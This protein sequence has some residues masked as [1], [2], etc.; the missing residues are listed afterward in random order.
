M[1]PTDSP[2]GTKSKRRKGK[3]SSADERRFAQLDRN[4]EEMLGG[5]KRGEVM[6]VWVKSS[7]IVVMD[8][9]VSLQMPPEPA[10]MEHAA[11]MVDVQVES[12]L[13]HEQLWGRDN[14]RTIKFA[15]RLIK[16]CN[17]Y[18]TS[19]LGLGDT[20]TALLMFQKASEV[21]GAMPA[22]GDYATKL[23]LRCLTYS[24]LAWFHFCTKDFVTA[25][26]YAQ[27]SHSS[28]NMSKDQRAMAAAHLN[29]GCCISMLGRHEGAMDHATKAL[30]LLQ[31]EHGGMG[32][33]SAVAVCL[34][35]IGV[36]QI[37]LFR[38]G[39]GTGAGEALE[40]VTDAIEIA[41]EVLD[42]SHTWLKH[43]K[44]TFKV[45]LKMSPS[46]DTLR[47]S[48]LGPLKRVRS[49]APQIMPSNATMNRS[50][51]RTAYTPEGGQLPKIRSLTPD[52]SGLAPMKGARTAD[53]DLPPPV[54]AP[55]VRKAPS[56]LQP[57][58]VS[59]PNSLSQPHA[60]NGTPI[61]PDSRP[62]SRASILGLHKTTSPAELGDELQQL[63][64]QRSK[65][66]TDIGTGSIP[67]LMTPTADDA[68]LQATTKSETTVITTTLDG[69]KPTE[70]A[71]E[72]YGED[73]G[74]EAD[75]AYGDDDFAP[76]EKS[77]AAAP[78]EPAQEEY[79]EDE[80]FEED[81]DY[82]DDFDADEE[83]GA[84]LEK[85][86][87]AAAS[88]IQRITR[89][90]QGRKKARD[91]R[92][93]KIGATAAPAT[94]AAA[95]EPT[96]EQMQ[97]ELDTAMVEWKAADSTDASV[98]ARAR[99]NRARAALG[100]SPASSRA[101]SPAKNNR[102]STELVQEQEDTELSDAD[103]EARAQAALKIQSLTRGKA[104][105]KKAKS[106]ATN[107]HTGVQRSDLGD[108]GAYQNE[109]DRQRAALRIQSQARAR[110]ARK[111]A[112]FVKN[113]PDAQTKGYKQFSE[114][115][116]D[117]A[118]PYNVKLKKGKKGPQG[119]MTSHESANVYANQSD[120]SYTHQTAAL[121]IQSIQRGKIGRRNAK[122]K[123]TSRSALGP[124]VF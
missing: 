13:L 28:A 3:K 23:E 122:K 116:G 41:K 21:L 110:R 111:Q 16:T 124:A 75:E 114:Y 39:E 99:V 29:V 18:G 68:L 109:I 26:K 48:G 82:G 14:P 22:Q 4:A 6:P 33:N 54:I 56:K 77:V 93:T 120:Y 94:T 57:L 62:E 36:E 83:A 112:E 19:V 47:K 70:E 46:V 91:K 30:Y 34:H 5:G 65:M 107:K 118:H 40:S 27:K 25:L 88:N 44:R 2:G 8:T 43:F 72:N 86:K 69:Y 31:A 102:L 73:D 105:R 100:K 84:D 67:R 45:A 108:G 97:A 53:K 101:P 49:P 89:G 24:N 63:V 121:R 104:G 32:S 20:R 117:E 52:S 96:Q 58:K 51:S 17:R 55:P 37:N 106:K 9:Q 92:L 59:L 60:F 71:E 66:I 87:V 7:P 11:S 98:E 119:V 1:S 61:D 103:R 78:Q 113:N 115:Q 80:G 123:K 42:E 64:A 90:K 38:T 81:E 74:F 79:G 35:N 76:E 15:E 85:K 10:K 95:A 50:Q 12:L